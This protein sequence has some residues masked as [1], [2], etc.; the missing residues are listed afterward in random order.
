MEAARRTHE[1]VRSAPKFS[2]AFPMVRPFA[3]KKQTIAS[4][5]GDQK[6]GSSG[7]KRPTQR[8]EKREF[9]QERKYPPLPP[10][11]CNVKKA[12]SLIKQWVNDSIVRLPFANPAPTP[13]NE[14]DPC[15]CLYQRKKWHTL[16]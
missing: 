9:K 3:K 2:P 15:F 6:V 4:V 16:D 7:Q 10:L 14:K 13:A 11:P 12:T 1:L 8:P 5:E